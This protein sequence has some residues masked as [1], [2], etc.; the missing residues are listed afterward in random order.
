MVGKISGDIITFYS[1]KGGT[2]RTMALANVAC[3]LARRMSEEQRNILMIDWDLE[4][5]GLHRY[6]QKR[7]Q[8]VQSQPTEFDAHPG[9]IDLFRAFENAI[10]ELDPAEEPDSEKID[11]LFERVNPARYIMKTSIPHLHLLK[12]GGQLSNG[13]ASRVTNFQ[14]D[15]FFERAPWFFSAFAGWLSTRYVYTLIDSRTGISDTSGICTTLL[16][17]KLVVVFTA[18]NQ[19]LTGVTE[20]LI[21]KVMDY[22]YNQ[23]DDLRPLVVYPLPSRIEVAEQ[24]LRQM[25]RFGDKQ[26]GI[27][28]YQPSFEV[29]FKDI[30]KLPECNLQPYFDEV[31][32]QHIP[33]YAYGEEI[34]VLEEG[35]SDSLSLT[36]AY[37]SFTNRLIDQRT[38][39]DVKPELLDIVEEIS[40][41]ED[42]PISHHDVFISY[43]HQ[44][45]D[46]LRLITT[47]LAETGITFWVDQNLKPGT[48]L[49][50]S[51]IG[52]AIEEA[53]CMIVILSPDA[54]RSQWV[55]SE[56]AY[57]SNEQKRIFPVLARG[58]TRTSMPFE[59]IRSQYIDIRDEPENGV[60]ML[61]RVIKQYLSSN[62]Q[63]HA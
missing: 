61:V 8:R 29:L 38:P 39:W 30:H 20:N 3:L 49:W 56:L 22:R 41:A 5:P 32:I 52:Q 51:A 45:G 19:S 50:S 4:A 12:A 34:A 53:A 62:I 47:A 58:D 26:Q 15:T 60:Q 57:A 18:N 59:L 33:H 54:K 25:W 28:G 9:L 13:Y 21:P 46:I 36:R 44:D 31:Q 2:G 7:M 48:P 6:F 10:Q 1:Y 11:A 43:S 55:Q 35:S 37:E 16:P 27:A 17:D 63:S 24:T 14:W 23:T 40:Q 42:Q